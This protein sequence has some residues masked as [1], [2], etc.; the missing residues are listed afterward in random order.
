MY[1][2][3]EIG[4]TKV[5]MATG[6]C[7][8]D[9]SQ[10]VRLPTES[11]EQTFAN[12]ARQV[13]S[14]LTAYPATSGI[15][16]ASFGPIQVNPTHEDFGTICETPKLAWRGF[17]IVRALRNR[18]PGLPVAL[19][20]DVN[21]AA[22]AEAVWGAGQGL[23]TFAY[24]TIGTG[25]G[26]GLYVNG[27]P[28]HGL[29]HPEAGH[30]L[31]RRDPVRDPF[32]GACPFHGDCLEGVASG[33]SIEQRT[34]IRG[35]NLPDDHYVW[36]LIG[37]YLAQ[38]YYNMTVIAA[39]QRILVGGGVGLKREVLESSRIEFSK[40]LGGYFRELRQPQDIDAFIRAAELQDRAGVLGA[41]AL[42]ARMHS[43][44]GAVALETL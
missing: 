20:T 37:G 14:F 21:G 19:D 10:P 40:L 27:K 32:P 33:P 3:I 28:I 8:E 22:V 38:L 35:E 17:N 7:P 4:G 26:A 24:V 5:V 31:V 13:Q 43:R 11:P 34:G 18:F 25:I 12:I 2:G 9:M 41:I 39:P 44:H 36:P 29:L 30:V 23:D 16:V 1:I 6:T 15:G 42:A